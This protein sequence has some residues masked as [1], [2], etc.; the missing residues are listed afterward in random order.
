MSMLNYAGRAV[1]RMK[2][3]GMSNTLFYSSH[4]A[5]NAIMSAYIDLRYGGRLSR[6]RVELNQDK[7]GYHPLAHT[8]W[9]E[10]RSIFG[11]VKITPD[12]VLADI[13]CGDGR[14][15]NYWMHL[16]L[17]NKLIGIEIDGETAENAR[18]AYINQPN[19]EIIHGDAISVAI[20]SGATLFYMCNSFVDEPLR[21][22]ERAI[23]GHNIRL[24]LSSFIDLR[25]FE[26]E[27]WDVKIHKSER[28]ENQYRVAL[29]TPTGTD[30]E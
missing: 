16:G 27:H 11:L 9:R 23:R 18:A 10:L 7:P 17:K 1:A 25:P 29:I 15:L 5:Q 12:D 13:G 24:V 28:D 6:R 19:I 8:S 21:R 2:S 3:R 22:F 14:V 20:S 30:S 26:S 4:V